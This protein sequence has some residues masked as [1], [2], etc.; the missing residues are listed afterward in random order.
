[1]NSPSLKLKFLSHRHQLG[2][3]LNEMGLTGRG[4][5]VGTLFGEYADKIMAEWKGNLVCV[6]PWQ[7]QPVEVYQDSANVEDMEQIWRRVSAKYAKNPRV[8]LM[9]M[10]SVDAAGKFEDGELDFVFLDGN[11]AIEAVRD[12]IPAWWTKVKIGGIFSGHD[13]Y[14]RYDHETN[15]DAMTPVLE[16]SEAIGIRPHVTWC[17]SWWFVKTEEAD[18]AFRKASV[19]G[20]FKH[21]V[22][23]DNSCLLMVIVLPVAKFDWHLAVKWLT[24]AKTLRTKYPIVVWHSPDLTPEQID[25]LRNAVP[26]DRCV[27]MNSYVQ[28]LGYFGT[29]NQMIK[30]ALEYC[31]LSFKGHAILWCEADTV[32]M[33]HGWDEAI[34]AEYKSCNRPF[35]GDVQREGSIAHLTGN[36]VYHPEWRKYAPSLAQLGSE[37]CGWDSLCAHDTLPKAHIAKT[38]QQIWRPTL[39]MTDA[40]LVREGVALF[41][42]CKDGSLIDALCREMDFD[43]IPL[44]EPLA[45]S[46][47]DNDIHRLRGAKKAITLAAKSERLTPFKSR[48][49]TYILIVSCKR[50]VEMLS[51]LLRSIHQNVSGFAGIVLAVPVKDVKHFKNLPPEVTLTTFDEREGK[52]M[53]HHEIIICRA[54]ELCPYADFIVHVDSDCMFWRKTTPETYIR[55]GRALLVRESYAAIAP[56]NPNRLIWG[57]CV[58]RACGIVPEYDTMVRHPNV[59]PRALYAHVRKLVEQHTGVGFDDYVFSCENGFPQGFAEFPLLGTVGLRDFKKLFD[60]VEY[61]WAKDAHECAI[62]ADK[63]FQYIYRPER[64]SLVE[65]WSHAGAA[66]YKLDWERF[67][68]GQLPRYYLK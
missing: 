5:E 55:N 14:V 44:A 48:A 34:H 57:R 54:D 12:D 13:F 15:S 20:R 18:A 49:G 52:G 24:W 50:D 8:E 56:R 29:P 4:V 31:Q 21:S 3:H 32:P 53:L 11:H 43:Q 25:A 23:S 27:V 68:N 59:Y 7:N 58:E 35:M 38:I 61:D 66:R 37:A 17:N 2:G 26:N 39:P 10:F 64:D 19:E 63:P 47:Y 60:V 30:T 16:L 28:E 51:Y 65:G 36:A 45:K 1:M 33:F 22:F 6:D 62:H 40:S 42:Q 46:T 9:R 41:H 67:L